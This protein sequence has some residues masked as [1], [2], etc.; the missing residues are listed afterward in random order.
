MNMTFPMISAAGS[1]REIGKQV[2]EKAKKQIEHNL[3]AYEQLFEAQAGISWETARKRASDII[4]VILEY[5]QEIMEEIRGISEGS[6]SLLEDIV[7]LNARSEIILK[8]D[9]CTSLGAV[10]PATA[11]GDVILGQNWDWGELLK[12]G[13]IVLDIKQVNGP[14]ILMVTEAGIVGKIGMNSS[15]LGVCL[16]LMGTAKNKEDGVPVHVVLRGILNSKNISQAVGQVNRKDRGVAANFLL[17]HR[18]GE[19]MDVEA[20]SEDYEVIYPES[21]AISHA[22]HFIGERKVNIKDYGRLLYP[23]SHLRQGRSEKLLN[24]CLGNIN[25]DTFKNIFSDHSGYPD[26]ICRHGELY[27]VED[28]RPR[29]SNTVFSIIM[30]LSRGLIK[31]AGGQPCTFPYN[32]ISFK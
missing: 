30:N 28:G 32:T 3:K 11:N 25:E 21:G 20:S 14:D 13:L 4:P 7:A 24:S 29:A 6:G 19:T 31:V 16:N 1:G 10:S 9:G 12:D 17:A 2:G 5:D 18:E 15:G 8:P 27:P 26:S 22:N 23:D